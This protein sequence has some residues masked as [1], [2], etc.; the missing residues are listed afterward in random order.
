[1]IFIFFQLDITGQNYISPTNLDQPLVITEVKNAA[2]DHHGNWL[3]TVEH[4]DDGELTP[5]MRL[6]FWQYSS[7]SQRYER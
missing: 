1:M 7:E 3:A 6:K 4:W 5:E 2:F